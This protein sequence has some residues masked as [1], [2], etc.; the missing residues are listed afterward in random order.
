MGLNLR[1]RRV[2]LIL[3]QLALTAL[4]NYFAFLFRFDGGPIPEVHVRP[5]LIGLPILLFY[6]FIAFA[7]FRLHHGLWRYASIWDLQAIVASVALSSIAFAG[8][9]HI[10]LDIGPYPRW[11]HLIDGL[12]LVC[13]LGGVRLL[14][15]IYHDFD[16][17]ETEK[18][19]LIFGAGD[20]GEMLVRDM[21]NNRFYN[22][23]P[24]GFVDDDLEKV[25]RTIHG[26][27]VL[28]TRDDL[29]RIIAERQPHEVIVATPRA[30]PAQIRA[31]V[32]ALEPYKVPIKTLPNLRDILSGKTPISQVRS[33]ALEDLMARRPVGLDTERIDRL[34]R[35]RRV[36][37]TG[38]GGSIGSELSRQLAAL[39]PQSLILLDHYENTL[40]ELGQDL[41]Q[42][43]LAHTAVIADITDARRIDRIFAA[44][45]PDLVFH[46]A[47]HKH[48]PLMEAN[49]S[50]A[51]KNNI[52]GTRVLAE[53]AA[54]HG[55]SEFVLISS[56]K[57][58]NPSSVMGVTK[59]VA[60][61]IVR[62]ATRDSST[63]FVAVRFGNVLGSNGSVVGLFQQQIARGGPVTVTHPDM[64][65]FFMLIP[66]AVSLVLHAAAMRDAGTIYALDMGEQIRLVDFARNMI[67]LAG[68]VP[69][70]EIPITFI[71]SR[72]GEK[73]YE[74]L[75]EQ[76]E[77]IEVSEVDK[78]FRV[79]PA[80]IP[81]DLANLLAAVESMAATERDDMVIAL[82]ADLVPSFTPDR[83]R[84][85]YPRALAI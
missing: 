7:A 83:R 32:R 62:A 31:I 36:L 38:A 59:R 49:P 63:R 12:V 42:R 74:E 51:V 4:S 58:V 2:L 75:W 81:D 24:V 55:V 82:L 33:L 66:E 25:G 73:L 72:P 56:D 45:K 50:E 14:R 30:Q 79:K 78:V 23:E 20:A 6:R 61:L 44:D 84:A 22:S 39:G 10:L 43:G 9:I 76:G 29:G 3:A 28:G 37:V 69:E 46:A 80:A 53:A 11:I 18:R 68:F 65:R 13:L 54:K 41:R 17:F 26:V 5:F 67:R 48:V 8:T 70:E 60:E 47:A 34:V 21:K 85:S 27:Q 1:Y 57:A 19:V 35:D 77:T 40:F 15:R 64:R 16:R 71:G 52:G